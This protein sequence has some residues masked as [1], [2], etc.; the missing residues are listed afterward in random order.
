MQG[1]YQMVAE[2]GTTF[3]VDIPEFMLAVPAALN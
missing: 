3:E 2:D 1:S